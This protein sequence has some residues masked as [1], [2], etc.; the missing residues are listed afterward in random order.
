MKKNILLFATLLLCHF[1]EATAQSGVALKD[2]LSPEN[3]DYKT[4]D[5]VTVSMESD[6][7]YQEG[8]AQKIHSYFR[9]DDALWVK[10]SGG[11]IYIQPYK[12]GGVHLMYGSEQEIS[13]HKNFAITDV[14]E[15][16]EFTISDK[17]DVLILSSS[18]MKL[19]V[20]KKQGFI[21]LMNTDG[22]LLLREYPGKARMNMASD[23][24]YAYCRFQLNDRDALYGLG[25]YRDGHLN[26]RNVKRE[27]VQFNTQAA[28]PVIYS[29]G[30]WG[31]FWNNVSRTMYEDNKEGMSFASDYGKLVDYYLFVG[32]TLDDL[33]G[34]YRALTGTAPMLPYWALGYHQSRNRYHNWTELM[35][36]TKRM[37]N[38]NIPMSTIFIDYH[39]WGKYGT[40]SMRFDESIFPDVD[41]MLDSIHSTYN[42][43]VV[44]TMWPC[45]KPGTENYKQMSS[46]GYILEGSRAIDGYVYDVFNPEARRMYRKLISPLLKSGIDGWF[47]DGP[48]PDHV[49]SFL[50]QMTYLGSA[51]KVRNL[52]PLLHASNFYEAITE[53]RPNERPYMLTRCAWASQQKYG[54][55]VWSGDIPATFDELGKQVVAGLDFVA[56]GIPYWTTDIGGYSGGNP[57]DEAYR[58]LFTR[59]FQYGTF[60]PVFRAHGRRYPG[61]TNASN[62]LWAYGER[63]QKICADYIRMRYEWMPYI[64]SLSADVTRNHYTPMR[65]LAFDFPEDKNVLD[66][67]DQFMYGPALMVCPV[68]SEGSRN[69]QVYLPEGQKW[70][71][72]RTGTEYQGGQTITADASLEH[73]PLYVRG[74]SIIPSY[75]TVETGMNTQTPVY[76]DLYEGS[77]AHFDLYEDD[78]VSMDYKKGVYNVIPMKWI[79]KSGTLVIGERDGNYS[80][81]KRRFIIRKLASDGKR[82]I[83][84]KIT[85]NGRTLKIRL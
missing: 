85:Y 63:V 22:R 10:T 45:F 9:R 59:W 72:Y 19:A 36:V 26:L 3:I 80:K 83:L 51:L 69:R 39:Y 79:E 78:G 71:D 65:L 25:Q 46:K 4:L 13:N 16:D 32:E 6:I 31:I 44:V 49:Q 12:K 55:A 37:K 53:E 17:E 27:L 58:E 73:I 23:S 5:A 41:K 54:T 52:Y 18:K 20:D 77:D 70:I 34:E 15:I 35:D 48:E 29:T 8:A 24:V 56:T 60:C 75:S 21:S 66:C 11:T 74:G 64:Y 67:K 61:D 62:E 76:I 2:S 57:A 47:L 82:E 43:K 84:K 68:L 28:V 30:G 42:T 33:V 14:P 40:G 81:G 50:P 7:Q 1:T 38:E